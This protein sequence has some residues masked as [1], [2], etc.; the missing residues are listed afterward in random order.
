MTP[1]GQCKDGKGILTSAIANY[2]LDEKTEFQVYCKLWIFCYSE[3]KGK[4]LSITAHVWSYDAGE[5]LEVNIGKL[6]ECTT[7]E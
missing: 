7:L 4:I 2:V 3:V 1:S 6:D 5:I